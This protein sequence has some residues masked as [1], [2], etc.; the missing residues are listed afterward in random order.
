MRG[1]RPRR[2]SSSQMLDQY[3]HP[4]NRLTHA[5][6]S[7]IAQ[8]QYLLREFIKWTLIIESKVA[9]RV[10]VNQLNRH[11]N[12]LKNRGFTDIQLLVINTDNKVTKLPEYTFIKTWSKIYEWGYKHIQKTTW[13]KQFTGYFEVAEAKMIKDEYLKEGTLTGSPAF[14]LIMSIRI[15]TRKQRDC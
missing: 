4:E 8:D 2:P 7:S 3:T 10:S 14:I 15:H 12:T 13:A 9:A 5:L 1:G 6:V 11:I